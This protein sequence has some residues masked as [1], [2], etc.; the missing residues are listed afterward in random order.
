M[1]LAKYDSSGN[2]LWVVSGGGKNG[3]LGN[4]VTTDPYGNVF[5][6]GQFTDTAQFS[7]T[8]FISMP[9]T[10]FQSS[11]DAF[12]AKYNSSGD[13]LWIKK[14]SG[15][16][17]DRGMDIAADPFGNIYALGQ[18]T[19][20]ITFDSTYNNNSYNA[21]FLLKC[22]SAGNEIWFRRMGGS[23]Q[24]IAYGIAVDNSSNVYIT[25]DCSGNIIFFGSTNNT[26]SSLYNYNAYIAKYDSNGNFLWFTSDGSSSHVSSRNIALDSLGSPFIIGNFKCVFSAYS[27][28][29]GSGIFNSIGFR[30]V[31]FQ[32]ITAM[33]F[34]S[35]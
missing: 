11:F 27:D 23:S 24:N 3:D 22:D 2:F 33:E 7:G 10:N 13:L 12:I 1:F 14:G 21:T 8:E 26:F 16:S 15:K 32:N 18:F 5:V 19:D 20:T 28:L 9:D 17:T 4:A 30:D 34:F 35:G 6:T 29:F 25:G 31:M